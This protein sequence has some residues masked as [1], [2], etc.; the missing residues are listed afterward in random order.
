MPKRGE[1]IRKRKD[2]RWE[3]RYVQTR[4]ADGKAKYASVYAKTY[5]EVKEKMLLAHCM[6]LDAQ[7]NIEET[8]SEEVL[9]KNILKKWL[10]IT[11]PTI[12]EQTYH[13]YRDL[14]AKHILP[15]IG[16]IPVKEIDADHLN[17]FVDEKLHSGRLDG[18]GGLSAAS[19]KLLLSIIHAALAYAIEENEREALCGKIQMPSASKRIIEVFTVQE[20][21]KLENF[22]ETDM[23]DRKFGIL[24]ALHTGM[25]LGELCGL[26]WSDIDFHAS[27][28]TIQR[29]V[30]RI[31][32]TKQD[33]KSQT[34]LMAGS[35][36]TDTSYRVVPIPPYLQEE[37]YQRYCCAQGE[38]VI[39]GNA[40]PFMDPRTYQYCFRSYLKKCGLAQRN[41][42]VLRHTFATRC[43]EV[44]MEVKTLSE[45]LGHANVNTTL[46]LYVHS[47][48]DSKRRQMQ[49]LQAIRGQQQE[50]EM[51]FAVNKALQQPLSYN[52]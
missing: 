12:K 20:Q 7:K 2:G 42:H 41:F 40:Y 5:A 22:L 32:C 47:S 14:I 39:C 31:K 49:L 33:A 19:V 30:Q 48:L 52:F 6:A 37:F 23:D 1:N 26:R 11:R 24:L 27:V 9:F 34:V 15:S 17:R 51:K 50:T 38:H 3:G 10:E 16:Y 46:N 44:G 35:P 29:T 36:K 43:M 25:R 4:S 45:L 28:I 21:R 8:D 18:S 13:R